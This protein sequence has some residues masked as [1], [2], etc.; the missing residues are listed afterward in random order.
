M[1]RVMKAKTSLLLEGPASVTLRKGSAEIVGYRLTIDERA[2][3]RKGLLLPLYFH[4]RSEIELILGEGA[5]VFE[6][7]GDAIP[8]SWRRAAEKIVAKKPCVITIIGDVD[9]GKTTFCTFIVNKL[10]EKVS[11]IAI[12][13]GDIGQADIGS[14]ATIGLGVVS[15]PIIDLFSAKPQKMYFIGAI[16]PSGVVDEVITGLKT[17][18][19]ESPANITIVNTDGWVQGDEAERYKIST[20]KALKPDIV[21]GIQYGKELDRILSEAEKEGIL[22]LRI[23]VPRTIK[24]RGRG[25]RKEHRELGYKKFL[26]DSKVRSMTLSRIRLVGDLFGIG[27]IL[28]HG[29]MDRYERMIGSHIIYGEEGPGAVLL[30]TQTKVLTSK[31]EELRS[32]LRKEVLALEKWSDG[33]LI[34]LGN[35]EVAGIGILTEIDRGRNILKVYTPFDKAINLIRLSRIRLGLDGREISA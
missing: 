21:V 6:V 26:K 19:K 8:R 25:E 30:V 24:R 15:S 34:G 5:D 10:I 35:R 16:S 20:I 11:P 27:R 12:V 13:D 14:P 2:V 9:S 18:I 31:V 23:E 4:K 22:S 33:F 32:R 7:R 3:I 28:T 29:E 17:M 1:L